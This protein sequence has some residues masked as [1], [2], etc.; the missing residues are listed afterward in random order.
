[1][2]CSGVVADDDFV[3]TALCADCHK[4]EYQQWLG[5]Q[6]DLAMQMA[7]DDTV[8]GDFNQATFTYFETTTTF[9]KKD[10]QFF[11]TTDGPTGKLE[12][13]AI[14]YTFGIYPLQQYLIEFPDGRI[15]SLSIAW[16]TRSQEQGGQRWFHLYPDQQIQFDSALH[17]TQLNQ[18]W[19]YMC[20][21]CHSTNVDKNYDPKNAN[22][23]TTWSEIDVACEACHGPGKKHID[24]AT[25]KKDTIETGNKGLL[26]DL[27]N[28]AQWIMN[29]ETGIA[30]RAS[31]RET[32]DE[33]ETCAFCHSRRATH[34]TDYVHGKK[35]IHSHL[36]ALLEQ[37]LY[38]SDGQIDDEV[39]V[40]GSFLQSKMYAS[41][42]TCS[43]CHNPHTAQLKAQGNNLCS[44]CHS[45][46][47][48]DTPQH[49]FHAAD[50]TGAQCQA[51]H[52]PEKTYMRVDNRA[53]HSFPIPRPDL[54]TNLDTPNACTQCHQGQNDRWAAK[55][56]EQWYPNSRRRAA[57][58][59]GE[60][61]HAAKNR[62]ANASE[63]LIEYIEDVSRPAIR[64]ATATT[65]LVSYLD[66][67][68][69]L[70]IQKLLN[71]DEELVRLSAIRTADHLPA[72]WKTE[73]LTPLLTDQL[74][75]I[76]SEAGKAL[77]DTQPLV[78]DPVIQKQLKLAIENYIASQ[79]V[80]ADRPEAQAN[81][82]ELYARMGDFKQAESAY[83][84]AIAL[85]AEFLSAY[86][87]LADIYRAQ[88]NEEQSLFYL[89]KAINIQPDSGPA[90]H[91]LGL[92]YVRQQN[93][94]AAI[95]HL[96]K[97]AELESGNARFNYIY[98]VALD[99][100]GNTEHSIKILEQTQQQH[101]TDRDVLY[102][103]VAY[104]Q[105]L[106]QSQKAKH[107][108]KLLT[109]ISP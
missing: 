103:L 85:D 62:H 37:G 54:S 76:R 91:S 49:H 81:L 75:I 29:I 69:L 51:C 108:A 86:V 109:E 90:H 71:D 19:N 107:Y 105:K 80:N 31:K 61:I 14:K 47:K 41:G 63:L 23:Q 93:L 7:T 21:D 64:R 55:N 79:S 3:G 83:Q 57:V 16:D 12:T 6:H 43:D 102:A 20:A 10:N 78:T 60:V 40:Y 65:L 50:S 53:D 34:Q 99:A 52:M 88:N 24:W 11:V 73:L 42:V 8:L 1:M 27:G 35:L 74:A 104:H 13:F 96:Q 106:G 30:A 36:P 38:H 92:Y 87:N 100:Q 25:T 48:F 17:W 44:A 82:G 39:F 67:N 98:A 66:S 28:H 59:Y 68:K 84:N 77:A 15:Q 56:I 97:S 95:K 5:S 4:Q 2:L 26:V 22:Y 94:P 45:A 101:P 72:E 9:F 18:N 32:H 89:N 70:F 33:I 58:H 46:A